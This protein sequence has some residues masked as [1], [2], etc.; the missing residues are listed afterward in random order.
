MLEPS[1]EFYSSFKPSSSS[2]WRDRQ[3]EYLEVLTQTADNGKYTYV[4]AHIMCGMHLNT[5]CIEDALRNLHARKQDCDMGAGQLVRLLYLSTQQPDGETQQAKSPQQQEL[6]DIQSKIR[7]ALLDFPWWP[8]TPTRFNTGSGTQNLVFWSENHIF[9]SLGAAH[10][11]RQHSAMERAKARALAG[12]GSAEEKHPWKQ[13]FEE[14][15]GGVIAAAEGAALEEK[16]LRHY[17]AVRTRAD[18]TGIYETCSHVYVPYTLSAL[19]NLYDFSEDQSLRASASII[20]DNVITAILMT[21]DASGCCTLTAS[22]R[23]FDRMRKRLH[24]H[25]INHL[26]RM[27]V[28]VSP[29]PFSGSIITDFITTTTWRPGVQLMDCFQLSGRT[30]LAHCSHA[31]LDFDTVYQT[32]DPALST[33]EMTPF[34]WSAGL[35]LHPAFAG[36]TKEYL[37]VKGM[38]ESQTLSQLKYVPSF[39][40]GALSKSLSHLSEGQSYCGLSLNVYKS[41]G[42]VLTSFDKYNPQR[43]GF[44]QLPWCLNFAGVG[45]WS[46]SGSGT[47][48]ALGFHLTNTHNPCCVQ[49]GTLLLCSYV[50]PSHLMTASV[51]GSI[52][53]LGYESWTVWPAALCQEVASFPPSVCFSALEPTTIFGFQ[54]ALPVGS[55]KGGVWRV[56]KRRCYYVGLLCTRPTVECTRS[57][58]DTQ[59]E[60][61]VTVDRPEA[62]DSTASEKTTYTTVQCARIICRDKACSWVIVVGQ[63]A[64]HPSLREFYETRCLPLQIDEVMQGAKYT[65]VVRDRVEGDLTVSI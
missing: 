35:I 18:F 32:S 6:A 38:Q 47:Q 2:Q 25:N 23:A 24:G 52:L 26:V 28:G 64:E 22:A 56:A 55:G 51:S 58:S 16:L 30:F 29:E 20:L 46:Q 3:L 17:C 63:E 7:Q 15:L 1:A 53:K 13:F 44:Q 65:C 37:K 60:M 50:A 33:L 9:M 49:T 45:M 36:R 62:V 5:S 40:A 21:T 41:A 4:S 34:A 54:K 12:S 8:S 43:A 31:A 19:W 59:V 11:A 10:L 42:I 27:L 48:G 61:R 57:F 39:L 14:E